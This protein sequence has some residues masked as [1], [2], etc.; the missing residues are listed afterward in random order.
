M[1]L[2]VIG[3]QKMVD[4]ANDKADKLQEQVHNRTEARDLAAEE[5]SRSSK[6]FAA[7]DKQVL[8]ASL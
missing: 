7:L 2:Q 4:A 8:L 6:R 5:H 1:S 3:Q